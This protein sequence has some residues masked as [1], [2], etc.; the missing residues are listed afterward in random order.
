MLYN[1]T[2]D[3]VSVVRSSMI[4]AVNARIAMEKNNPAQ[5]SLE[6]K[7]DFLVSYRKRIDRVDAFTL[8]Y[9]QHNPVAFESVFLSRLR[10]N[11]AFNIYAMTKVLEIMRCLNGG[12]LAASMGGDNMTLAGVLLAIHDGKTLES[13]I[14]FELNKFANTT[15]NRPNYSSGATQTSSSLRALEAFGIVK[16]TG[17]MSNS[18]MWGVDNEERFARMLSAAQGISVASVTREQEQAALAESADSSSASGRAASRADA[19]DDTQEIV[20]VP[21]TGKAKR[22]ATIAAKKATQALASDASA[23]ASDDASNASEDNGDASSA[24]S[25]ASNDVVA[26]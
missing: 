15:C 26:F 24:I 21:L 4:D 9:V 3:Q 23:D 18:Q 12:A 11:E 16:K 25:D 19:S 2:L 17:K 1:I 14:A 13:H 22:A 5:R 8:G 6:S 20:A 10:S 7:L